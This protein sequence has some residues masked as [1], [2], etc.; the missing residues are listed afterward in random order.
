MRSPVKILRQILNM[1]SS[2]D[3]A[4]ACEI[5]GEQAFRDALVTAPPGALNERAW[6]FWHRCYGI[7][8][9]PLPRRHF[10]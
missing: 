4:S 3:Y 2:S 6:V 1:G 7:E 5:W 9:K 10:E 8:M